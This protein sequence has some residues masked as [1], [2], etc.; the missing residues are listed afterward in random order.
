[1]QNASSSLRS[2][3]STGACAAAAAKAAAVLLCTGEALEEVSILLPNGALARFPVA[4]SF[5]TTDSA[6]ASI[7]KDAGD[8]PD[9]TNGLLVSATLAFDDCETNGDKLLFFAGEGVGTVT[10]PGL[11]VPPGE[12]AINPVPR[13]MIRAAIR[14]I[15]PLPLRVTLSIPGGEALAKK[16]FNPRLGIVGGLS[17]LGTTGIVRPFSL[18]ALRASLVCA[19]DVAVAAGVTHLTLVPGNIGE[20]A[21]RRHF[22]TTEEEVVQVSNFWGFML[23]ETAKR[24]FTALRIVGHPGKLAKLIDGEWDTHSSSSDSAVATVLRIADLPPDTGHA[25][26]EGIF[27]SLPEEQSQRIGNLLAKTIRSAIQKKI[28]SSWPL[29]VLLVNMRGDALGVFPEPSPPEKN[30]SPFSEN[31]P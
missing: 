16:T 28:P 7:R 6:S 25:T 14:E 5:S 8:D 3:F 29:S 15:T 31:H 24:P 17:I 21:A 11:S 13:Q 2:G 19:L 9:I 22:V 1:M 12:P 30:N 26:V 10:K 4:S 23:E 18:P 27:S 20:R